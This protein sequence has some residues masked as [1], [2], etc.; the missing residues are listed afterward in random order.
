MS[1]LLLDL[2]TKG[3]LDEDLGGMEASSA[4]TP[5]RENTEGQEMA[6]KGENHHGD[7]LYQSRWPWRIKKVPVGALTIEIGLFLPWKASLRTMDVHV[8][9][10]PSWFIMSNFTLSNSKGA[11]FD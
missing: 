1:A 5:C 2:K 10:T 9:I 4:A 6:F 11:F 7:A 8:L 3:L